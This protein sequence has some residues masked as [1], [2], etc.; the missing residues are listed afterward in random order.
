[1]VA[2]SPSL[3]RRIF[4][5]LFGRAQSGNEATPDSV[6]DELGEDVKPRK[7]RARR[8]TKKKQELGSKEADA[9]E[10]EQE[11]RPQPRRRRKRQEDTSA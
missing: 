1:L 11:A 7:K 5:F 8:K 4:G 2:G 3:L 9:S 10:L 6:A